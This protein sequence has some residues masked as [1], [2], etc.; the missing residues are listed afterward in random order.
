[1]QA[2]ILSGGFGTRLRPLTFTRPK[3]LMPLGDTTLLGYLIGKM[4]E[5]VDRVI[6]A[7]NY[8][9]DMIKSCD[10]YLSYTINS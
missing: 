7:S 10:I 8:R 3:S 5:S 6:L 4:P 1:M 9:I 2:L